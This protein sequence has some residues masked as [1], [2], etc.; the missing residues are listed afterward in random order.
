MAKSKSENEVNPEE[1][2]EV[3]E[4]DAVYAEGQGSSQADNP[5]DEDLPEAEVVE[6]VPKRELTLEEQVIALT[7]ECALMREK[8]LR[9]QADYQNQKRRTFVERDMEVRRRLQ[10]LLTELLFVLDFL[11]MALQSPATNPE[12]KN[13]A[14][15]VDMTRTRFLQTLENANVT[16]IVTE[17]VFDPNLHEATEAE[18][19]EGKP[20][21]T[22]LRMVRRGY[23]WND[24]VLR[25]AQVVVVA[26][27]EE[28][29]EN[30]PGKPSQEQA[31]AGASAE[32]DAQ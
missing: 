3:S 17:G 11:D 9:A 15:G 8:S 31:Q 29:A 12:T 13:L 10:P 23:E 21:G 30:A 1:A 25:H 19:V 26:G 5:I 27:D 18:E 20:A 16:P 2:S 24:V 28:P 6:D 14:I 32:S 4:H 7:E 22:I